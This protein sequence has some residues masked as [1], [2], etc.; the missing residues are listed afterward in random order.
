MTTGTPTRR[1]WR[2]RRCPACGA[3][4]AA[5]KFPVT[6]S[7]P[8]W[9]A[10]GRMR[11]SCPACGHVAATWRFGVVRERRAGAAGAACKGAGR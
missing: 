3:V 11:R 10:D 2:F 9:S 1:A 5:G 8:S 6:R 7:G 4:R